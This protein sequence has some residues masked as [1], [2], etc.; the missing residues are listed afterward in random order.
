VRKLFVLIV[1]L[2][3]ALPA[4][5]LSLDG[6]S[7]TWKATIEL[8]PNTELYY[9]EMVLSTTLAGF[10]IESESKFYSDGWRYQNFYISGDVGDWDVWGKIYF[11]AKDIRYQKLWL[12][13]ELPLGDGDNS[14]RLSVDHWASEDDY[15]SS[16]ED[17]FGPWPCDVVS[18]DKAKDHEGET[19]HVQGPVV[20]V[21]ESHSGSV[22]IHLGKDYPDPDRFDIYIPASYVD[23]FRTVFGSDFPDNLVG[24]TV[25]IYGYIKT[26]Y[27]IYEIESHDPEDLSIGQCCGALNALGPL[28]IYQAK[29]TYDPLTLTVDFADCCTGAW[30]KELELE[31]SAL[32]LCCGMTYDLDLLFTKCHGFDKA[33]FSVDDLFDLCCGIGFDAEIE[34]GVDHK[35]ISIEPSWEGIE[36]CLAVYGD[37]DWQGH[38]LLGWELYGWDISCSFGDVTVRE[39]TA[40]DPDKVED[41]TDVSFYTDEWEYLGI[42]YSFS[43]CCGGEGSF[44]ARF[45]FGDDG[46]LF[47]LQRLRFDLE[48]PAW[49]GLSF[50]IKAQMKLNEADPLDWL[51]VGWTFE[52]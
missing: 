41:M 28:M 31:L 15:W 36:G 7:G 32:P 12:N 8:L 40:L 45:W 11:S 27:G 34:F 18:W 5:A 21:Y 29:L 10:E 39:V 30:F 37:V 4:V 6:F 51:D 42:E 47:D 20:S 1:A 2:A 3:I 24:K 26:Y 9:S 38:S 49:E 16:D 52:F 19:L 25:C 43:G 14:L 13:F 22:T 48:V 33:V 35:K 44:Q 17:M 23:D 46:T 50:L